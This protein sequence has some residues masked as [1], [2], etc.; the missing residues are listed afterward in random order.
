MAEACRLANQIKGRNNSIK[1]DDNFC[2]F[3]VLCVFI[4]LITILADLTTDI[5]VFAE[6]CKD[7]YIYWAIATLVFILTP[8][9]L[10]NVFSMRWFI[11][12]GKSNLKHWIIHGCLFGLL[13]RYILF[14]RK[15]YACQNF[16]AVKSQKLISQR[17]DLSL[18]HFLYI[19]TGTI[20]QI[21]LQTYAIVVLDENYYTKVFALA[22]SNT[23]VIWGCSTYIYSIMVFTDENSRWMS[24]MLR[25]VW[26]FSMLLARI[27]GIFLSTIIFGI[28]TLLPLGLH[29]TAMTFWIVIQNTT[30]CPN[31]IEE[32]L[33]NVVMGFVYCFCYI[34]LREG[35]TRYR[36]LLFYTLMLTQNFGSL[37]LY[38]LISDSERQK[39]L[40]SIGATLCIIVGTIIGMCAMLV[41]YRYFH[42]K[43]PITWKTAHDDVELNNKVALSKSDHDSK[44]A[45]L[46]HVRSFKSAH[47]ENHSSSRD[48]NEIPKISSQKENKVDGPDKTY[49]LD[50]LI[51]RSGTPKFAPVGNLSLEA[52]SIEVYTVENTPQPLTLPPKLPKK[53][54]IYSPTE[55]TIKLSALQHLES[56]I[57]KITSKNLEA[58][59]RRGIC[60][61]DELGESLANLNLD[62]CNIIS[63]AFNKTFKT[64][65]SS[66][67]SHETDG[68]NKKTSSDSI[69]MDLDLSFSDINSS[70]I[71]TFN[72]NIVQ[73]LCL[74]ALKNIKVGNQDADIE[75]IQRIALDILKEMYA[76]KDKHK[77]GLHGTSLTKRDQDT[78][79]EILSVHDYENICAVNIAREAWGLRSWNGYCDIESWAHDG[80]VVRDRRRDTLTSASTEISSCVSQELKN[81]IT[82]APPFPRK[83]HTYSNV[84]IKF[85]K[86]NDDYVNSVSCQS[87]DDT[88]LAKPCVIDSVGV[89]KFQFFTNQFKRRSFIVPNID[90]NAVTYTER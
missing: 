51:A 34:N 42:S 56:S 64:D 47:K 81:A 8:N 41:Y 53:K 33:Y 88:F 72:E 65:Y 32:T 54:S 22:A 69:D 11:I 23:S 70:D 40:W 45:A 1:Q 86:T 25:L 43:G 2:V 78:P 7:G 55:L 66:E 90:I 30:F 26:H 15:I 9:I 84:F 38:V 46:K 82:T 50:H 63:E 28:W 83:P 89:R 39:K 80:S 29:W 36:I 35:H 68:S 61:S 27:S 67:I 77:S 58:Q 59:K 20:P 79:T 87:N 44:N 12:D 52:S 37:F 24:L 76:K 71:N 17:N 19:F 74:S 10:I 4:S 5:L 16:E 13:E 57:D 73:K 14:L 75:N 21:I 48:S 85:D 31:K 62:H 49:V 6:Y 18:L 60:S 3:S